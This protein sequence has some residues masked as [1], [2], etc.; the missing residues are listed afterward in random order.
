MPESA[1]EVHARVVAAVGEDG[2]LPAPPL[3]DWDI[4]PWEVLDGA[5]VPKVLPPPADEEARAGESGKPCP[6]CSR[7]PALDIWENERWIVTSMKQPTGLPLALFLQTK[8]HLDFT[9]MD[10]GLAA[11]YGRITVWLTRIMSHLPN[12]GRVH[13]NKWGDGG[14][15]LHVWFLAR[16]AR[17][18]GVLGSY[19]VEW[20]GILP[21]TPEE[22]W[23]AD[24]ATVAHKLATHGGR[25]RI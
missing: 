21:P 2:R 15:H 9:D 11:E 18:T 8:E 19:A 23:R 5:I 17:L 22:V 25:A 4:F 24:L 20:D 10:D 1:E 6:T 12:I 16:T 14:A 7:D 13:V 3:A